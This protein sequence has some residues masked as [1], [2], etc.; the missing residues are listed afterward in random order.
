[1]NGRILSSQ[2]ACNK[3]ATAVHSSLRDLSMRMYVYNEYTGNKVKLMFKVL[4][5]YKI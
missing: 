2:S 5:Q 3:Q 1:M 4:L